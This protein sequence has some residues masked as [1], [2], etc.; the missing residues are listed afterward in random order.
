MEINILLGNCQLV[1]CNRFNSQPYALSLECDK[2]LV[3]SQTNLSKCSL[4][5]KEPYIQ[6]LRESQIVGDEEKFVAADNDSAELKVEAIR[7]EPAVAPEDQLLRVPFNSTCSTV[8]RAAERNSLLFK[9]S[10]SYWV[11]A[12]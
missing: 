2:D 3:K 8:Q 1:G 9:C 7:N 4:A 12:K 6:P 5:G 10:V 11:A